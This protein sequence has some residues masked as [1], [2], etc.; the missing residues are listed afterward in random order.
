M[1]LM[2]LEAEGCM[3]IFVAQINPVVGAIQANLE[4]IVRQIDQAKKERADLVVFPELALSGAPL[5]DLLFHR[6]VVASCEVALKRVERASRG[7]TVIVG[8]PASDGS[9][10]YDAALIFHD[11][12]EV[13]RQ[14]DVF[15]CWEV[16]E[17]R[18][19]LLVGE[20]ILH[21]IPEKADI[22]V[23]IAASPWS[24]GQP[25]VRFRSVAAR[26][27]PFGIPYLF[28][29]LV[30]GN[31]GW[32]FDGNSFYCNGNG[33]K[34]WQ[35]KAFAETTAVVEDGVFLVETRSSMEELHHALLL[36]ISDFFKKQ[37]V[38]KAI[39]ALSGGI[40]SSVT[41]S[42]AVQALGAE[43]VEGVF[44]PYYFTSEES[45]SCVATLQKQL[46][47]P[48]RSI[49]IDPI[50]DAT[51]QQ[52][53]FVKEGMVYEN[54]QA[55]IRTML[56]MACSNSCNSMV[57]GTSN[58]TEIALG[59]T[60]IYGDLAGALLPI[61]DLF[62]TEVYELARRIGT[63]PQAVL[64]R[65]P[66]AELRFNQRDSDDLPEYPRLD[67]VLRDLIMEGLS[68]N[69][70][71]AITGMRLQTI[72]ALVRKMYQAEYKRRQG[73]CILRVSSRAFG[74]DALYPIVNALARL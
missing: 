12:K 20:A 63:I 57:L 72:Q 51:M 8:S 73:P 28:V 33:E 62:K 13:G 38:P 69:E 32:I 30:G 49:T 24:M 65:E 36:G 46:S 40:D 39:V 64:E 9:S 31:D 41:A 16:N 74:V 35:A 43:H 44:L 59:Y 6:D 47:I 19:G 11:G 70:L 60:T 37:G 45:R 1:S 7:I 48:V 17:K 66:T 58:K 10:V 52:T 68:P 22:I 56:L 27:K 23:H 54:I 53:G 14:H 18:I 2:I 25:E 55:R 42:L 50:V 26:A 71:T 34:R 67:P 4:E 15:W 21:E 61:G 5:L 29:N 3:R